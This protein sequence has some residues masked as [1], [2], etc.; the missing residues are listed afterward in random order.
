MLQF[1]DYSNFVSVM[2]VAYDAGIPIVECLHLAILTITNDVLREKLET[3]IINVSKGQH[4]SV[5][6]R[7]TGIVPKMILFMIATG[8]QSGRLGDMLGQCTSYIDKKLN[9]II[10]VLTKM[11]EPIML[12]VIGGIVCVLALALYMPLFAS[13]MS[14]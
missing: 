4:L 10:S 11:I 8:E 9:D 2:Q 12:L 3:T 5:A 13:Y 14:D 1:G 7:A 6:L